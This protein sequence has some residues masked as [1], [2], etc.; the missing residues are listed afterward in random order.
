VFIVAGPRTGSTALGHYIFDKNPDIKYFCEPDLYVEYLKTF[1]DFYETNDNFVLKTMPDHFLRRYPNSVKDRLLNNSLTIKLK[2]R[3][4]AAQ[5]ASL[6]IA[7]QRELWHY[8]TCQLDDFNYLKEIPLEIKLDK[9]LVCLKRVLHTNKV[10]DNIT[11]DLELYYEDLDLIETNKALTP[12]PSN[13]N[14]IIFVVT[15]ILRN[16]S[17]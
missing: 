12:N 10:L 6:Y 4:T 5:I 13:Y 2:R 11:T 14:E 1:L 9:V 15:N 8:D 3:D 7:E 17:Y 16:K